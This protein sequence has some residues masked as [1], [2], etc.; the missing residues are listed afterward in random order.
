MIYPIKKALQNC[1]ENPT[2]ENFNELE[3]LLARWNKLVEDLVP[4]GFALDTANAPKMTVKG[5]DINV[6]DMMNELREHGLKIVS[7]D[8]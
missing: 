6:F 5:V 4:R 7:K 1:R 2:E 8:K 3:R